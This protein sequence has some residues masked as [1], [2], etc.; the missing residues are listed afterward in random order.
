M[1]RII[2]YI[3]EDPLPKAEGLISYKDKTIYIAENQIFSEK[4]LVLLHESL[5]YLAWLLGCRRR[6]AR[7]IHKLID[8]LI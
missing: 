2:W 6:R 5:H 3:G 4:L 1:L 7:W 8:T